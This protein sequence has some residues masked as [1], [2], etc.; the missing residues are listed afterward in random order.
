MA[1]TLLERHQLDG[2]AGFQGRVRVA[3]LD[4]AN[5]ILWESDQTANHAERVNLADAILAD[6]NAAER[7]V[8]RFLP[9]LHT[10]SAVIAN[11]ADISD[12]DLSGAV[13]SFLDTVATRDYPV[14]AV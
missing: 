10:H 6:G 7:M 9:F 8:A 1:L 2:S 13:V 11:G 14:E 12:A 4:A 5:Q 3:L